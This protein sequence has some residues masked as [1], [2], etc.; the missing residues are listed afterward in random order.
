MEEQ[1]IRVT[2]LAVASQFNSL[3]TVVPNE[4]VKEHSLKAGDNIIWK[5]RTVM[6]NNEKIELLVI[7]FQH[8]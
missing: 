2:K 5:K 3:R 4:L 1:T 8:Q 6:L 7:E